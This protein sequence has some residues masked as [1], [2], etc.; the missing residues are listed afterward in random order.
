MP[1]ILSPTAL[2]KSAKLIGNEPVLVGL[3]GGVDSSVTAALI[4]Q[5]VG[6][7]LTCVFVDTGLLRLDEGNEVMRLFADHLGVKVIRVNAQER[8]S[9]GSERR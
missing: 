8:F 1:E 3:S 7:R 6:E 5:A 2:R 4:H 9:Q